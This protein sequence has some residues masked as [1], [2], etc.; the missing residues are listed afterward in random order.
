M[1]AVQLRRGRPFAQVSWVWQTQTSP[2]VV[3]NV[4]DRRAELSRFAQSNP[5]TD[6]QP[7]V[8]PA[9]PRTIAIKF[10]QRF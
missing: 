10:G 5:V 8:I 4:A 3:T 7:Y 9:Q 6:N 2:L 1:V